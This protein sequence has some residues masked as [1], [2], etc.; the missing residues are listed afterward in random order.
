[1]PVQHP[2]TPR[3]DPGHYRAWLNSWALAMRSDGLSKRTVDMYVDAAVLFSGWLLA[4]QP[5]VH[6]WEQVGRDHLREF[7]AW[8]RAGS[9]SGHPCPHRLQ[10]GTTP[11]CNGYGKGY[12]NNVGRC[13]Q[14]YFAW[15]ANEED[16]P[17]PFDKVAVPAAPKSDE[18]PPQV[19]TVD[20]LATLIKDAE[21]SRDFESRRDAAI[22]RLF[23]A[24]G[25]R[26][27]E[28]AHLRLDDVDVYGREAVVTG[29]GDRKRTVRFDAK[30]ARALDRYLRSRAKRVK[31]ATPALWLGHRGPLTAN[32]IYQLLTRRGE[33]LG[34][35][36]YPHLMRHTFAHRW[37]DEGGAEGDLMALAGWESPQMLRHYGRSARSARARRA[38]DRVDVMGGV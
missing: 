22:L 3:P 13:L 15:Y 30:A 5:K 32:G 7:F 16:R 2:K 4:T 33:R 6:D 31:V 11:S 29:K 36:L 9:E 21:R 10:P 24:T 34:I 18:N 14:Q 35:Q 8:L 20:Q 23:A 19:L 26:L 12:V 27:G 28:L 17:N 25:C 38:Y 1:M 37:L